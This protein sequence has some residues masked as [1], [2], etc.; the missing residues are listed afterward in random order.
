V[1]VTN[2]NTHQKAVGTFKDAEG[3]AYVAES[4]DVAAEWTE[5]DGEA[6]KVVSQES[7]GPVTKIVDGKVVT[8][9]KKTTHKSDTHR[10]FKK[11]TRYWSE[12]HVVASVA[13]LLAGF[14]ATLPKLSADDYTVFNAIATTDYGRYW[15][16][17]NYWEI[18]DADLSV[19][20]TKLASVYKSP[21]TADQ[22]TYV[23][24]QIQA[25]DENS[26]VE[27]IPS[28]GININNKD[29]WKI[30]AQIFA[31][32][33]SKTSDKNQIFAWAASKQGEYLPGQYSES[34]A[35]T[36]AKTIHTWLLAHVS[37]LVSCTNSPVQPMHIWGSSENSIN[38]PYS[39]STSA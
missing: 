23:V 17:Y 14:S 37:L 30:Y 19:A 10:K 9:F 12:T 38:E 21:I 27:E 28:D 22:I 15:S 3:N 36:V 6:S 5:T 11:V 13:E 24:S 29:G 20:L 33:C 16:D 34:N 7:E 26:V 39:E 31:G 2:E 35:E 1:S 25:C 4:G 32:T 8:I 18:K